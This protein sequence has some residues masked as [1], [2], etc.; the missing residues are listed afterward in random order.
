VVGRVAK[1]ERTFLFIVIEGGSW[2][3]RGEW[4]AAAVQIQCFGLGLRGEAMGQ[5][6][7]QR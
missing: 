2:A 5:S 6:V 3:V 4:L 1:V 7:A